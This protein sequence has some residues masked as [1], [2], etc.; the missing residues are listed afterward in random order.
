MKHTE[1]HP[2]LVHANLHDQWKHLSMLTAWCSPGGWDHPAVHAVVEALE[3]GRD[4]VHAIQRLGIARAETGCSIGEAFDDLA[5]LFR[6]LGT[7]PP[8]AALRSLSSGWVWQREEHPEAHGFIEPVSGLFTENYLA[9]R[10]RETYNTAQFA[11]THAA[12]THGLLMIDVSLGADEPAHRFKRAAIVGDL[13]RNL[14][15]DGH[16]A[17][18]LTNGLFTVLLP[19]DEQL[20]ERIA[21]VR[22]AFEIAATEPTVLRTPPRLWVESL[23]ESAVDVPLT[24]T[25]IRR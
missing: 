4:P 12:R 17:A 20:G 14:F 25:E 8:A 24:L 9:A 23:P 5:C 18:N 2:V 21:H 10:L 15:G 13:L 1:A 7:E 16:P 11:G 22:R 3:T 19:R 6:T